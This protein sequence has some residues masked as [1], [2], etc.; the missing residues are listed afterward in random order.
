M[1]NRDGG[2]AVGPISDVAAEVRQEAV[3]LVSYRDTPDEFSVQFGGKKGRWH[4]I[5]TPFDPAT[6]P[7]EPMQVDGPRL[8]R[9]PVHEEIEAVARKLLVGG[10]GVPLVAGTQRP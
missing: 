5:R 6:Q 10:D 9:P 1:P 8:I 2:G 3:Q 7:L 4:S